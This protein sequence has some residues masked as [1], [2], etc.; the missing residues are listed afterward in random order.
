MSDLDLS[1][2][3]DKN[4][5]HWVDS[6]EPSLAAVKALNPGRTV[7]REEV[8]ATGRMR[9]RAPA[10]RPVVNHA[11]LIAEAALAV[12]QQ[13]QK[14][15]KL[16][17]KV[18]E[19]NAAFAAVHAELMRVTPPPS[20]E[21]VIREHLRRTAEHAAG[22]NVAAPV[23]PVFRSKLDAVMSGAPR[24]GARDSNARRIRSLL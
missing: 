11:L 3:N 20:V 15:A 5:S 17:A 8:R 13:I 18:K 4:P 1:K 19:R 2:L 7:T 23:E 10:A 16:K 12:Q 21:D 14:I 6:G 22:G 9:N 24:R